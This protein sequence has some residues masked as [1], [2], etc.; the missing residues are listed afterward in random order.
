MKIVWLNDGSVLSNYY[1]QI[2][3]NESG[4]RLG[5]AHENNLHVQ[6]AKSVVDL[7]RVGTVKWSKSDQQVVK[8]AI[9]QAA[10]L[11]K[12]SAKTI[13]VD[14]LPKKWKMLQTRLG[15]DWNLPYTVGDV[16]VLNQKQLSSKHLVKILLHEV[17]HIAQRKNPQ[18]FNRLY[19]NWGFRQA[20]VKFTQQHHNR[21][22]TNPDALKK[23]WVVKIG[24]DY[25]LP[26]MIADLDGDFLQ[27]IVKCTHKSRTKSD[28]GKFSKLHLTASTNFIRQDDFPVYTAA[29]D[30]GSSQIDHPNEISAHYLSH[31]LHN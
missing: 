21:W 25:C 5:F 12:R 18:W 4:R 17:V 11:L 8:K 9:K 1:K 10:H 26:L 7:L 6:P 22:I 31:L 15:M 29:F 14:L 20:K 23:N 3:H 24:K 28:I 16:I 27:V 13:K 30:V 2:G 19:R